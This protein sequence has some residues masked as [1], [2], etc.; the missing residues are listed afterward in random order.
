MMRWL[1]GVLRPRWKPKRGAGPGGEDWAMQWAALM[2]ACPFVLQAGEYCD[3][4]MADRD[5]IP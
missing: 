3:S 2:V 5:R 1:R 4:G